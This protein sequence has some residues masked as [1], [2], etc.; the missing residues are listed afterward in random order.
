MG[1]DIQPWIDAACLDLISGSLHTQDNLREATKRLL[2]DANSPQGF[3]LFHILFSTI[4]LC[5]E[6]TVPIFRAESSAA[7]ESSMP[8]VRRQIGTDPGDSSGRYSLAYR[9][10]SNSVPD[11]VAT[12]RHSARL[13]LPSISNPA[14][15]SDAPPA[16]PARPPKADRML[17]SAQGVVAGTIC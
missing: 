2:P 11:N 7:P 8:T 1:P 10:Y 6:R 14:T 3:G 9:A 15:E 17:L 4:Y 13:N 16:W 12:S 5:I